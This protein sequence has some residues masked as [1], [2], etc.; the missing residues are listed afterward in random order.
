[1]LFDCQLSFGG[2]YKLLVFFGSTYPIPWQCSMTFGEND[3]LTWN[4]KVPFMMAH[5]LKLVHGHG[6]VLIYLISPSRLG[7][8]YECNKTVVFSKVTSKNKFTFFVSWPHWASFTGPLLQGK[9]MC[10]NFQ[11]KGKKRTKEGKIYEN[12]GKNVQNLNFFFLKRASSCM[13]LLHEWNR[14]CSVS[15]CSIWFLLVSLSTSLEQRSASLLHC[16]QTNFHLCGR[17]PIKSS[18]IDRLSV[19]LTHFPQDLLANILNFCLRIFCHIY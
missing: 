19:C 14:I 16:F 9:D 11:K 6:I 15:C 2:W 5:S 7:L 13:L 3:S 4:S 12:L 1:M 8:I 10:T 17:D 18:L